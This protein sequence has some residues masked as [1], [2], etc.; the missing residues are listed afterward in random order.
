MEE[1]MFKHLMIAI[2]ALIPFL[3]H[4]MEN[5]LNNH[6]NIELCRTLN[7]FDGNVTKIKSLLAQGAD[8]NTTILQQCSPLA[9]LV[10]SLD[11]CKQIKKYDSDY[12]IPEFESFKRAAKSLLKYGADPKKMQFVMD[13]DSGLS[14]Q[15]SNYELLE[16][17]MPNRDVAIKK[18]EDKKIK[19][20]K[21]GLY[22]KRAT[23]VNVPTNR[24]INIGGRD[25][26]VSE[27]MLSTRC[28][29]FC[30]ALNPQYKNEV[31]LIQEID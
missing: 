8:P 12:K 29:R 20:E 18:I 31:D 30:L 7:S 16:S 9:H 15:K 24:W 19:A 13:Y 26:K 6:N 28:L 5:C 10:Y 14:V 4:G 27:E 25:L 21:N 3:L 11:F 1:N 23:Q 22:V 2:F 17:L